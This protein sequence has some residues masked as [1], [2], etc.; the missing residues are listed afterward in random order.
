MR[1]IN[2]ILSFIFI[3]SLIL[4]SSLLVVFDLNFYTENGKVDSEKYYSNIISF[5]AFDS[6]LDLIYNSKENL[7]MHDVRLVILF[8]FILFLIL[9]YIIYSYSRK[10]YLK[11]FII[12][13]GVILLSLILILSLVN[14]DFLFNNFHKLFFSSG[15]WMFDENSFL[16]N[17]FPYELFLIGMYLILFYS[18]IFYLIFLI[19]FL[20]STKFK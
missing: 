6:N 20:V 13:S 7:H 12:Y 17:L 1:R 16:L 3:I 5:F 4:F 8:L 2:F 18:V 9:I 19:F 14:F 11:K 10:I 15:S